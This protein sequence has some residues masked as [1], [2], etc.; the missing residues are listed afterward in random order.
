MRLKRRGYAERQSL[1]C[2]LL[3][4]KKRT[5]SLDG[6]VRCN[7]H[8]PP[9]AEAFA[10]KD[11]L[12]GM[13]SRPD[14]H[15]QEFARGCADKDKLNLRIMRF[16]RTTQHHEL[17]RLAGYCRSRIDDRFDSSGKLKYLTCWFISRSFSSMRMV[18]ECGMH[19]SI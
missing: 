11:L 10:G 3:A 8:Q 12:Q 19:L 5:P 2:T 18:C 4:S 15:K 13:C 14:P 16:L 9:T 1:G 7:L 6:F 17:L